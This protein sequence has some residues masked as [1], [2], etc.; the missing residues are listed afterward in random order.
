MNVATRGRLTAL[1]FS[2]LFLFSSVFSTVHAAPVPD[3]SKATIL[4]KIATLPVPIVEVKNPSSDH[5]NGYIAHTFGGTLFVTP[6][7]SITYALVKPDGGWALGERVSA[8]TVS[9][10]GTMPSGSVT[11]FS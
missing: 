1:L 10:T 6:D 7:G 3:T 4:R 5:A 11:S 9:P 2:G 8:I